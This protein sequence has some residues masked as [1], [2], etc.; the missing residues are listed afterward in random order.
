MHT[1][2]CIASLLAYNQRARTKETFA[3]FIVHLRVVVMVITVAL[4]I[5]KV[6]FPCQRTLIQPCQ[7]GFPSTFFCLNNVQVYWLLFCKSE[8]HSMTQY[9]QSAN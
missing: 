2:L 5:I 8:S 4:S 7:V 3:G 1:Y 6:V 9:F